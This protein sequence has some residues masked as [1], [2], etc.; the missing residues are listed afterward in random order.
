MSIP[1][2][3]KDVI[4]SRTAEGSFERG[5]A[6]FKNG[7]VRHIEES[8]HTITARVKGSYYVPYAVHVSY[9]AQGITEVECTCPYFEGSWCKHIV[10]TLLFVLNEA[11]VPPAASP[12]LRE[13]LAD[14]DR[15]QLIAVIEAVADASPESLRQ[16]KQALHNL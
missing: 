1:G 10:A 5:E 3:T 6:Y 16:V 12:T 9:N 7:A 13:Q 8:D 4:Q 11:Q 15:D 14:L 2:L